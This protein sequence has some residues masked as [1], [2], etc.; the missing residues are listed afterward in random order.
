MG[1]LPTHPGDHE[2]QGGAVM[3]QPMNPVDYVPSDAVR[4]IMFMYVESRPRESS[5]WV[6]REEK[7]FRNGVTHGYA[8][9]LRALVSLESKITDSDDLDGLCADLIDDF[10]TSQAD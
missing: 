4:L 9:A 5:S 6:N 8:T 10:M 7:R 1:M 2:R 3:M